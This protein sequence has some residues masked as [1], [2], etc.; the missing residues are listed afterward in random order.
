ME[1][2]PSHIHYELVP[3]QPVMSNQSFLPS[4]KDIRLFLLSRSR[5]FLPI[6]WRYRTIWLWGELDVCFAFY[7]LFCKALR[8]WGE[9]RFAQSH[10]HMYMFCPYVISTPLQVT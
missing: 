9:T 3:S 1:H 6:I 10:V 4:S 5:P 8:W 7:I 2:G